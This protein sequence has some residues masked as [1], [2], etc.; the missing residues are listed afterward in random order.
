MGYSKE[1]PVADLE[2]AHPPIVI[3]IGTAPIEQGPEADREGAA[4]EEHNPQ[5]R[6]Y[7]K[8][9]GALPC[10][11]GVLLEVQ[12]PALPQ[13]G[14]GEHRYGNTTRGKVSIGR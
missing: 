10:P 4:S 2:E 8:P 5:R 7:I 9:V 6:A 3:A 12:C 11:G 14:Q 13:R 1:V